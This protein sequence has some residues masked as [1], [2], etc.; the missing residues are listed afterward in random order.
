MRSTSS[1]RVLGLDR[2]AIAGAKDEAG[3]AHVERHAL[4]VLAASGGL[5]FGETRGRGVAEHRK[6]ALVARQAEVLVGL[7]PRA[8]AKAA[9]DAAGRRRATDLERG[10]D[11]AVDLAPVHA[12]VAAVAG[13][14]VHHRLE[15]P[16]ELPV[17]RPR[18]VAAHRH[19]VDGV[20]EA[21]A[22]GGEPSAV[23]LRLFAERTL[24]PRAAEERVDELKAGRPGS[25]DT[26]H[27][28]HDRDAGR[29]DELGPD[30][31]I[32]VDVRVRVGVDLREGDLGGI[33]DAV[34]DRHQRR[35]ERIVVARH[36]GLL[37]PDGRVDDRRQ[38]RLD[39]DVAPDERALGLVAEQRDEQVQV[40][41]AD[42]VGRVR[43]DQPPVVRHQVVVGEQ[44]RLALE[45]RRDLLPWR[46]DVRGQR[47]RVRPRAGARGRSARRSRRSRRAPWR[48]A[49]AWRPAAPRRRRRAAAAR[50]RGRGGR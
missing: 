23:L 31:G 13:I 10:L 4:D 32:G 26:G 8:I 28:E 5:P 50:R 24:E 14:G 2:A 16:R 3:V 9:A 7:T 17:A 38:A 46:R 47:D 30:R 29:R 15:Q 12:E 20:E 25:A 44:R 43:V 19:R 1:V 27:A 34:E 35:D 21:A 39:L 40:L 6:V 48:P 18:H 22:V 11:E 33:A 42:R 37:R 45:P 49:R 36:D 41:Q